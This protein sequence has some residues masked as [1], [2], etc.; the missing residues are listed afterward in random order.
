MVL[1]AIVLLAP[2]PNANAANRGTCHRCEGAS[3]TMANRTKKIPQPCENISI[4]SN[5]SPASRGHGSVEK[6]LAIGTSTKVTIG[7]LSIAMPAN[8]NNV[9]LRYNVPRFGRPPRLNSIGADV[10]L[11]SVFSVSEFI[12]SRLAHYVGDAQQLV[13][14]SGDT[15]Q[16]EGPTERSSGSETWA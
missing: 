9:D 7:T 16:T 10:K 4:K 13:E 3:S 1:F 5:A 6:Y 2:P 11:T 14:H 15:T 12:P 8:H